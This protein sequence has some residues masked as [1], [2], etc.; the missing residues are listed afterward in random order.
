MSLVTC[1]MAISVDGYTA[2]PGQSLDEPFGKGGL[3]LVDWVFE[4]D[5]PDRETDRQILAAVDENIG[6]HIMGRNMFGGGSGPWD[7]DWTGWWGEEPPYHAPVYVLTHQPREPLEMKGGTTFH[8]VTDGI[9]S[10]LAQARQ[11]AAGKKVSIAGGASTVRQYLAAGLIDEMYLHVV[12][13]ILGAG[14]RPFDDIGGMDLEQISVV[15]SPTV[16]HIR[17]K[18]LHS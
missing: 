9:E 14:E 13:I 17:Y 7:L 4:T 15:V 6:A 10:A 1:R 5:Q 3:R 8:F 18:V 16:T 12:P 2:A 11:V